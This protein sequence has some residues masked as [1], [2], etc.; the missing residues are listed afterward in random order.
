MYLANRKIKSNMKNHDHVHMYQNVIYSK[1]YQ[2]IVSHAV[3]L[4]VGKTVDK[5]LAA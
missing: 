4:I 1:M 5:I 3:V 2:A